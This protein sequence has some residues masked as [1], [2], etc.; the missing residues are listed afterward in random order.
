[1]RHPASS[2]SCLAALVLAGL[3]AAAAAGETATLRIETTKPGHIVAVVTERATATATG[4]GGT[5][6]AEGM[7]WKD[8]CVAPC[9]ATVPAGLRELYVYDG[10]VLP[11]TQKFQFAPGAHTVVVEPGSLLLGKATMVMSVLG[12]VGAVYG[13]VDL[14]MSSPG[15]SVL[16]GSRS[17]AVGITGAGAA[18]LAAGV[19]IPF[20]N[21]TR[22]AS[23]QDKE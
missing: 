4:P 20:F 6:T 12:M 9:T 5:A 22:F 17:T 21:K 16:L 15:G 3:P 13:G 23:S 8:L 1:M 19:T 10:G 7:H 18:L 2:V 11:D 14:A